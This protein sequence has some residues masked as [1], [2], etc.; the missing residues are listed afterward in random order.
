[1]P[2]NHLG[3]NFLTFLNLSGNPMELETLKPLLVSIPSGKTHHVRKPLFLGRRVGVPGSFWHLKGEQ[4][5]QL[6]VGKITA[7][8][9]WTNNG[10]KKKGYSVRFHDGDKWELTAEELILFLIDTEEADAYLNAVALS[11]GSSFEEAGE[12]EG[13]ATEVEV[14]ANVINLDAYDDP[15]EE[16][17]EGGDDADCALDCIE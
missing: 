17:Y 16:D 9:S 2:K 3:H 6:Y 10:K 8:A 7:R 12:G 1:M 4:T 5:E 14:E 15:E 13:D 11:P